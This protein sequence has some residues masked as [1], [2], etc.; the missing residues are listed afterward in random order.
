VLNCSCSDS[1]SQGAGINLSVASG[2]PG[3]TNCI[4]SGC[5]GVQGPA[6]YA[7]DKTPK[8]YGCV[9]RNNTT[10]GT[11]RGGLAPVYVTGGTLENCIITTT[12]PRRRARMWAGAAC[13]LPAR[14][15]ATA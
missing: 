13:G 3:I 8:V 14:R 11:G 15:S 5:S 12:R 4:V 10:K 2:T 1:L 9:F 6:L 7:P